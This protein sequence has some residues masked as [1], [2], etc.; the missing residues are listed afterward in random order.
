[1]S[2]L[3]LITNIS[4]GEHK[5]AFITARHFTRDTCGSDDL[6]RRETSGHIVLNGYMKPM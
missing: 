6:A 2:E 3:S 4:L 5:E 1:M